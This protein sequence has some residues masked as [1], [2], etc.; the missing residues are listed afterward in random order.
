MWAWKAALN[1]VFAEEQILMV[2][3]SF[4]AKDNHKIC[5]CSAFHT[6]PLSFQLH[7]E[8]FV[9][10]NLLVRVAQLNILMRNVLCPDKY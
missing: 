1:L 3:F 10:Q 5:A 6:S 4:F 2:A 9:S 8:D 7:S